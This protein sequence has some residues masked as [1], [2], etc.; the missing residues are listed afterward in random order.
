[1]VPLVAALNKAGEFAEA[2][3]IL[4]RA[5][6]QKFSHPM[7]SSLRYQNYIGL[8]RLDSGATVLQELLKENPDNQPVRL[9]LA[10]LN[11][12]QEKWQEAERLLQELQA[13]DPQSPPVLAALIELHAKQGHEVEA[14]RFADTLV[15]TQKDASAYLVRAQTYSLLQKPQQAEADYRQAVALDPAQPEAQMALGRFYQAQGNTGDALKTVENLL[16]QQ[17]DYLPAVRL[18]VMLRMGSSDPAQIQQGK[19]LLEQSL[20]AHPEDVELRLFR[21]FSLLSEGTQ[22]AIVA[23]T[24]I[25]EKITQ[26][27]PE[28]AEAWRLLGQLA[29][30]QGQPGKGIDLVLRGLVSSPTNRNLLLLKAQCEGFR[31][32]S[33]AIPT[34]NILR[35][36]YPRD[37]E[38]ILSL[39]RVHLASGS[40]AQAAALL[41]QELAVCPDSDRRRLTIA[42]WEARYQQGDREKAL[43]QLDT[44]YA[45]QPQ[46]PLPLLTQA[47]LLQKDQKGK[48]LLAK[49]A[50]W[51]DRFP[52]GAELLLAITSDLQLASAAENSQTAE[53]LLRL[54]LSKTPDQAAALERLAMLLNSQNRIDESVELY[55]TILK[56][57]PDNVIAMNNLAWILSENQEKYQEALALAQQ[58]LQL[59]PDYLDLRDTRGVIYSRLGEHEKAVLDFQKCIELYPAQSP[60]IVGSYLH[61]G[62]ALAALGQTAEALANLRQ[63]LDLNQTNGGLSPEDAAAAEQLVITLSQGN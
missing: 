30:Q 48:E 50:Q 37:A 9:Q 49:A 47:R 51:Q 25:L 54:I 26:D 41:E 12:R 18:A 11:M 17:P 36:L 40:P 3:E 56:Q 55:R 27:H 39:A 34:L 5:A 24:G 29:L 2:D 62:R 14:L 22:P 32:P 10:L 28:S 58:G 46:D 33:L 52:Q 44:L 31:T 59:R 20:A 23:A 13:A 8:G 42:L 35:Q 16:A 53:Q 63:A 6:Q 7:L 21:V 57:T 4:N 19:T 15:E 60:G 61:L 45:E 38:I 1:M 43:Q